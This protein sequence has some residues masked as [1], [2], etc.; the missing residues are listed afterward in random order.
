MLWN[1][2]NNV[3]II[4]MSVIIIIVKQKILVA[5][6]RIHHLSIERTVVPGSREELKLLLWQ[7]TL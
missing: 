4:I 2:L 3:I 1:G 7:S 6:L 5:V